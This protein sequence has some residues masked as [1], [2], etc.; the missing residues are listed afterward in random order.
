MNPKNRTGL[1][2]RI[3][4]P[5]VVAAVFLLAWDL[6]VRA[7]GSE[8]FPKPVE[9][10]RGIGEL[11]RKGVLLKCVVASL[12]RVTW[13]FTLAVVLGV[14]I[15]LLLGWYGWAFRALNPMIQML[16]PIS[17]IAWIPVAIL[18]FGISD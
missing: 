5:L 8:I 1:L 7:S 10:L 4:L 12:F 18:W 2:G 16:R 17:P 9:V 15:G 13:G 14:P 6:S 3:V 11:F